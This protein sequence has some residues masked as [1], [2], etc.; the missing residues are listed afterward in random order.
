[1]RVKF[2]PTYG[3]QSEPKCCIIRH[4]DYQL[5]LKRFLL[6]EKE[7]RICLL[8]TVAFSFFSAG[9]SEQPEFI[10]VINLF[11]YFLVIIMP[12]YYFF[13]WRRKKKLE[14]GDAFYPFGYEISL[15]KFP[16]LY[17]LGKKNT[18]SLE[19]KIKDYADKE[20]YGKLEMAIAL[21]NTEL[22]HEN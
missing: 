5:P 18:L 17:K 6:G 14:S 15:S 21:L 3:Q 1:M 9:A 22:Q 20:C 7:G 12:A 8:L 10:F 4:M 19:T 11:F 2:S 13:E 16:N